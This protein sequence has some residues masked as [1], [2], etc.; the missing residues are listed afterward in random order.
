M[1]KEKKRDESKSPKRI[2]VEA[3]VALLGLLLSII[4]LIGLLNQGWLGAFLTYCLVYLFG[5]MYFVIL[6]FN[7]YFGLYLFL[8]KKKPTIVLGIKGTAIIGLL[9]FLLIA[10]S[11]FDE[12]SMGK[13]FN[14][15]S[16]NFDKIEV[17]MLK[18]DISKISIVGGGLI[19]YFFY[20]LFVT[21]L[22]NF[23]TNVVVFVVI[24]CCLYVLF[25]DAVIELY[26]KA[27][28]LIVKFK[29]NRNNKSTISREEAFD[30][31][32][33]LFDEIQ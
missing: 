16:N 33:K 18:V 6:L 17:G 4:S 3:E 11:I 10:S 27:K 20:T 29:E 24:F 9:F 21:F 32:E 23:M 15:F 31:K 2:S 12:A 7:V 28:T 5:S 1:A 26:K 8:K 19:G 22:D 30:K 14:Y 25:K 13:W